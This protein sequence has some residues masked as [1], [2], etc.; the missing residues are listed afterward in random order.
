MTAKSVKASFKQQ[1]FSLAFSDTNGKK[2]QTEVALF[3]SV[4]TSECR[5]DVSEANVVVVLKK[6]VEQS[7]P[8]V[9]RAKDSG[10]KD[11]EPAGE[12]EDTSSSDGTKGKLPVVQLGA[13][14]SYRQS[15]EVSE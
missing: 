1:S 15:D 10:A 9:T 6:K 14:V 5:F 13:L 8:Q 11:A 2:Y 4:T 12:A 7:W 3:A